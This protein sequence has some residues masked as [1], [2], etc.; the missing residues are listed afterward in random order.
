[1]CVLRMKYDVEIAAVLLYVGLGRAGHRRHLARLV[2]DVEAPVAFG[3]EEATVRKERESPRRHQ[4]I[5]DELDFEG[6]LLRLDH[7]PIWLL[8]EAGSRPI[9][10]VRLR[11]DVA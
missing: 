1:R 3:H 9:W 2:D 10:R 11:A 7:E 6:L 4:A 5:G 8:N